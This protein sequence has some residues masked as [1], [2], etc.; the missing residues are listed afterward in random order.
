MLIVDEPTAGLDPAERVRFRNLLAIL[1]GDRI[2]ILSTHIVEDIASTC[3]DLAILNQGQVLLRGAPNE[4]ITAAQR[5]VWVVDADQ[6]ELAHL[7][8][9]YH[10][11]STVRLDTGWRLRMLADATPSPYASAATPTIEDG[12]MYLMQG[13]ARA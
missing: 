1:S 6:G 2:V 4:L 5:K 10:I 11:L 9:N 13:G 3:N 12:Y 8:A 7:Q